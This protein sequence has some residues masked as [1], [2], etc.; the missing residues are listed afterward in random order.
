MTSERE[1]RLERLLRRSM[2]FVPNMINYSCGNSDDT[3][4][5]DCRPY[6]VCREHRWLKEARKEL[7]N[8]F[9]KP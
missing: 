1:K 6:Y 3:P 2:K 8:E 7:S 4:C 5:D 9:R